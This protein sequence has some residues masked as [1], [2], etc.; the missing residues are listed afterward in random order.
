MRAP[1][2]Y[3]RLDVEVTPLYERAGRPA[4]VLISFRD[5]TRLRALH[6]ELERS[7]ADLE[8]AQEEI[9]STNEE[10]ETTNEE[11][12][13]TVEELQTTNEE[14]QSSNEEL[15]TMNEELQSTN[16]ELRISNDELQHRTVD[17]RVANTHL[18]AIVSSLPAAVV[19]V[20]PDL[21]IQLWSPKAEDLWGVRASEVTGKSFL[22]IDIGLAV[23]EVGALL[24]KAIEH[25]RD[26]QIAV[27]KAVNRRGRAIECEVRCMPLIADRQV[28][29]AVVLMR[30]LS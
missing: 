8:T 14:L 20:G 4:G 18:H 28:T 11:L 5:V 9:R 2:E 27:I 26:E 24:K 22:A 13:S 3:L 30:T 25:E 23:T 16:D 10:L 17:A 19:V 1:E 12:Q 21:V 6:S 15:E 7:R 29:G